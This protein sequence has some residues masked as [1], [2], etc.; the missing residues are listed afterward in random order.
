M[1]IQWVGGWASS[2]HRPKLLIGG[3]RGPRPRF[4]PETP[5]DPDQA[6]WI[7]AETALANMQYGDHPRYFA[8]VPEREISAGA[9][10]RFSAVETFRPG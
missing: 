10:L 6:I 1:S 8:R 4:E 3:S 5:G 9:D 7:L 2:G